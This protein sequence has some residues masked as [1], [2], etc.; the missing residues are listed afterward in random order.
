MRDESGAPF[1]R[2]DRL[3]S[4]LKVRNKEL[5]FAMNAGMYHADF[6]PV[7]LLVQADASFRRSILPAARETFS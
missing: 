1:R 4:W 6:S 2:L 7:G 5:R 3:A